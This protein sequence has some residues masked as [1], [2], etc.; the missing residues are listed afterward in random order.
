MR[1]TLTTERFKALL[2]ALKKAARGVASS[3]MLKLTPKLGR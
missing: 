1:R 3:R 2:T